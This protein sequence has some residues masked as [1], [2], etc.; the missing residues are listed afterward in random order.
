MN[1]VPPAFLVLCLAT[2]SS[3]G[4]LVSITTRANSYNKSTSFYIDIETG[5]DI[6]TDK[7]TGI[8]IDTDIDTGIN[9]DIGIDIDTGKD[10]QVQVQI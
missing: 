1:H 9:I 6:D 7:G 8:D 3:W 5:I 2:S 4:F 10:I